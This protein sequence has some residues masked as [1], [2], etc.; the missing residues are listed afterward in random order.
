MVLIR[1]CKGGVTRLVPP[2]EAIF[3]TPAPLGH[4]QGQHASQH[5]LNVLEYNEMSYEGLSKRLLFW[6]HDRSQLLSKFLSDIIPRVGE[7]WNVPLGAHQYD[8]EQGSV[9]VE[10]LGVVISPYPWHI[11]VDIECKETNEVKGRS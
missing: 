7:V 4:H 3:N 10:V 9:T 2:L 6:K 11:E 1:W 5:H 8:R